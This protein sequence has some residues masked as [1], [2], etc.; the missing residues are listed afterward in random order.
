METIDTAINN[1]E[2]VARLMKK[3][4]GQRVTLEQLEQA[5]DNPAVLRAMKEA[6]KFQ[7]Q[8]PKKYNRAACLELIQQ[9]LPGAYDDEGNVSRWDLFPL[10]G[11]EREYLANPEQMTEILKELTHAEL[12]VV[13]L[14]GGVED[15]QCYSVTEVADEVGLKPGQ[16]NYLRGQAK[17]IMRRRAISLTKK[18]RKQAFAAG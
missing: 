15:G 17:P 16:V 7:P 11:D 8:L 18:R 6:I 9:I 12:R 1:I 3:L 10:Y 14:R 2:L 4:A 13:L 5:I